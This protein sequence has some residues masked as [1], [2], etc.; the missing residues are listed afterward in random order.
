MHPPAGSSPRRPEEP[1]DRD[2]A[3]AGVIHD[4][5][6]MLAVITGRAE[7]LLR[8]GL[9]D[10]APL[11]AIVL[12]AADAAAMLARLGREPAGQPRVE[13]AADIALAVEAAALLVIPPDGAWAEVPSPPDRWAL[14]RRLDAHLAA[15]VPASVVREVL[16]NLLTNAVAALPRGGRIRIDAR[17]DADRC[18]LSVA[19]SGPG[20]PVADPE[21]VF[22]PG[23]TTSGACGRGIG[24]AACRQLLAAH[25]ATLVA[26]RDGGP[27]AV[28]TIIAP[29]GRT[30]APE[31]GQAAPAATTA[32]EVVV[33]DDEPAVREMLADVLAELGCTVTCHRDGPG[34]LAGGA[35]GHATLALVDRRL[36]GPDGPAVAVS[37][38][39]RTPALVVA[40]M[41]GWD[42]DEIATGAG[43]ADFVLRKPIALATLQDLL[44][45]ADALWHERQRASERE[46][47]GT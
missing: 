10:R 20:L 8:R 43:G 4:V 41:T 32:M 28:F 25:G 22:T 47:G 5:N 37:L 27:G 19:D 45:K 14:E 36:P 12:A 6:Q 35:P 18:V 16:V 42:R 33:V 31:S 26:T 1:A 9:V 21:T 15:A 40:L 24:L 44:V 11:E 17:R 39:A 46:P 2:L 7:L 38:R 13:G 30:P 29:A 3:T 34:A 23:F